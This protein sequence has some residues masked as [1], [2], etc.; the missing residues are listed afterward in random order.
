MQDFI[1]WFCVWRKSRE[2]GGRVSPTFFCVTP[3]MENGKLLLRPPASY[4][5]LLDKVASRILS[6]IHDGAL[7][8]K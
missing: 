2:L 3:M 7:R 5:K 8:R 6:N 4:N 1:F